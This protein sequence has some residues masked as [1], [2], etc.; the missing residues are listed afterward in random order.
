MPTIVFPPTI[1]TTLIISAPEDDARIHLPTD[2]VS[3]GMTLT[4][5]SSTSF[6]ATFSRATLLTPVTT[7]TGAYAFSPALNVLRV[8]ADQVGPGITSVTITTDEHAPTL[9]TLTV[10]GVELYTEG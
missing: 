1:P 6:R 8:I 3:I 7:F 5:L 10:Y 9:Y 2:R 4:R